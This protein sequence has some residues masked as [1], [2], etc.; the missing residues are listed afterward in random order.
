M[1]TKILQIDQKLTFNVFHILNQYRISKIEKNI[2][3]YRPLPK[4][5]SFFGGGSGASNDKDLRYVSGRQILLCQI[6]AL[7][8]SGKL[9]KNNVY[10]QKSHSTMRYQKL[11]HNSDL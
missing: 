9:S 10:K 6:T 3:W 5:R 7:S 11:K 2:L 4:K 1:L 8:N